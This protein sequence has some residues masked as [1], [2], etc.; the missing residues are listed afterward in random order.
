MKEYR[1][2]TVCKIKKDVF[3]CLSK[4]NINIAEPNTGV[5]ITRALNIS[6][7][8]ILIKGNKT[9]LFLKPGIAKVLLV[10]NKFTIDMVVLIPAK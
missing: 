3:Q 1:I 4:I 9:L 8:V 5:I 2:S 10:A 7:I 6:K